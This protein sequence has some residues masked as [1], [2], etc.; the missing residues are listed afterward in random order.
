MGV[1]A[2]GRETL[3]SL[4]IDVDKNWNDR[5]ISNVNS[6][7]ANEHITVTARGANRKLYPALNRY[8]SETDGWYVS[9]DNGDVERKFWKDDFS[10]DSSSQYTGDVSSFTWDTANRQ[11]KYTGIHPS[12]GII[13]K[14]VFTDGKIDF[15]FAFPTAYTTGN[16]WLKFEIASANPSTR[17]MGGLVLYLTRTA[18]GNL[19]TAIY[20]YVASKAV[21]YGTTMP[22]GIGENVRVTIIKNANQFEVYLN[23]LLKISTTYSNYVPSGVGFRLYSDGGYTG[24]REVII[25]DF[26][27]APSVSYS[28]DFATDTTER[29]QPV[30]GTVTYDD[31]NNRMNV[32]TAA[33]AN[34]KASGRLK[35]YK[36]CE[37][38]QQFDVTLPIGEDGDFICMVTHA[39]NPA[40]TNGI[41]V[42]LQSDGDGNWNLATLSGTTV[43]EG[44][45]SGLDDGD[46]ARIEIEKDDKGCYW[47]YIYDASGVKPTTPTGKLFTTLSEGYTGW[48]ANGAGETTQTYAIDNISIRA[49]SIVGRTNVEV[50][51]PFWFRDEFS[52]NSLGRYN[53]ANATISEGKLSIGGR[54]HARIPTLKLTGNSTVEVLVESPTSDAANYICY[55]DPNATINQMDG[56]NIFT[57]NTGVIYVAQ[58]VDKIEIYVNSTKIITDADFKRPDNVQTLMRVTYNGTDSI[59][60]SNGVLTKTYTDSRLNIRSVYNVAL[61]SGP[62]LVG[63]STGRTM[64]WGN[65]QISGTRVYNKPIHRGA[66][67]ETFHDG[68]EEVVGTTFI[69]DCQWDRSAE[70]PT[71]D[72]LTW[73]TVNSRIHMTDQAAGITIGEYSDFYVE[74]EF[75]QSDVMGTG[76]R[77]TIAFCSDVTSPSYSTGNKYLFTTYGEFE[78]RLMNVVEGELSTISNV[79]LTTSTKNKLIKL[80][81][82]KVGSSIKCYYNGELVI[83]TT[84]TTFSYGKVVVGNSIFY[85]PMY[86]RNVIVIGLDPTATNG[87]A[88]CIPP[89]GGG[90]RYG[91]QEKVY[92]QLVNA[93][94]FGEYKTTAL[95]KTTNAGAEAIE[96]YFK[97]TTDTTNIATDDTDTLA[98]SLTDTN[99]S[100]LTKDLQLLHRD[101]ADTIEVAVRA[102][103]AATPVSPACYITDLMI[104]PKTEG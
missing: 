30:F 59:T 71:T 56:D 27:I 19:K 55:I 64:R 95:A 47:Y 78:L 51:E 7:Q 12:K 84:N 44:A 76:G 103:S 32:T 81:V 49:E 85:E 31:T 45:D 42:G 14:E 92:K 57:T 101:R 46:V 18:A 15:T 54:R 36:F 91:E 77:C 61:A 68:T 104:L 11:L 25:K 50:T 35:S 23:G 20:D 21:A 96:M 58:F 73:D 94:K 83:S 1:R 79:T 100:M 41:G 102:S 37:G 65:L 89:I 90:A 66:M 87:I 67:L 9:K 53:I 10:V 98:I 93:A 34:G 63:V 2:Y 43:T 3:A 5:S 99:Y 80:A 38:A 86:F 82:L 29:Y 39:T 13:T 88:A 62:G 6:L 16:I 69:D 97:N 70:Y 8:D 17:P 28:D 72:G 74:A 40:M 24:D 4:P 48:R 33:G 26:T 52:E 75:Y 22:V 60:F